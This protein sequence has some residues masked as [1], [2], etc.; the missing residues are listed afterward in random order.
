M[1]ADEQSHA[2]S[3]A[4]DPRITVVELSPTESPTEELVVSPTEE[5]VLSPT[6]EHVL[7]PT[8]SP[9]VTR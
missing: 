7:S 3:S 5:Q 2:A 1:P 6:E 8:E 4:N 9:T